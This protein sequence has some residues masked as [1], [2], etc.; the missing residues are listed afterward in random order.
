MASPLTETIAVLASTVPP[1]AIY[2]LKLYRAKSGDAYHARVLGLSLKNRMLIELLE[3]NH[4]TVPD[5]LR[6]D[7]R[8]RK[9][10]EHE[11]TE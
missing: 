10:E 9:L 1:V 6:E 11:I 8:E 4:V 7:Y 5:E 3:L 2:F